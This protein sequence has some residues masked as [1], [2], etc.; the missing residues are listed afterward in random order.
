WDDDETIGWVYEFFT[1]R[2]VID[3][4]RKASAAPRDSYEMAV[5]NQ[6]FT[7]R[8]VV[9]FLTDNTLGRLWSEMRGGETRL[10]ASTRFFVPPDAPTPRAKKDPRD[11][12]VLDPACGSG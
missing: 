6:F 4:L 9:E 12:R 7:P 8:Y 5:R 11:I 2:E 1:P 3:R 10:P